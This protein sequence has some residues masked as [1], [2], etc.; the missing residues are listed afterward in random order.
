LNTE[1]HYFARE[2]VPALAI[3][4]SLQPLLSTHARPIARHRLLFLDTFDGRLTAAGGR[5][6]RRTD[7]EGTWLEWRPRH[8][9]VCLDVRLTEPVGFAWDL[10][11]GPLRTGIEPLVD[12]RRLLPQVEVELHGQLLNILDEE[13]K[14]VARL[15]IESGRARAPRHGAS[16]RRMPTSV[17]LTSVRGYQEEFKQLLPIIESR[18]GLERSLTGLLGLAFQAV[19]TQPSRDLAA[20][21]V[22]LDPDMRADEGARTIHRA[23]LAIL[24]ANEPGMCADVD[25][26]FLHDYRVALRRTRSLLAQIRDVFP[27][28]MVAHFREEFRWL[29][30]VTG[31]TRDLDV[32]L[33]SLRD[34][35]EEMPA[36]D[37]QAL[38][39]LVARR[40]RRSHRAMVGHIN[41]PR[42]RR[43][44]AGW[45]EFLEGSPE[46]GAV[47]PQ[48]ERRIEDVVA[49]RI[50]QLYRR[51][52]AQASD[53]GARAPA[54]V[55]H[56]VRLD[57]KKLR[58]LLDSTRALHERDQLEGLLGRLKRL[59]AVLGAFNDTQVQERLLLE[60]GQALGGARTGRRGALVSIGRL[61]EQLRARGAS[62]RPRVERALKRLCSDE[63]HA[64]V[65]RIFHG[66]GEAGDAR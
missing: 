45:A 27:S 50:R 36:A 7:D 22:A 31:P 43:L 21:D 6:A 3:A 16:W 42:Y 49:R 19:G 20:F 28:D 23:L 57:A 51:L 18:P 15:Q 40:Q 65:R 13:R 2:D 62:L 5:L 38:R 34:E 60:I 24:V 48:A 54:A 33:L 11:P 8:R 35:P 46:P 59:Q 66:H 9:Q 55:V 17:T 37:H 4:S 1:A 56:Q 63:V 47:P 39:S 12:V 44:L 25:S 30:E 61:A 58:Y 41:S 52:V 14:T 10:P 29:G 32:L 64:E 53:V 26:E